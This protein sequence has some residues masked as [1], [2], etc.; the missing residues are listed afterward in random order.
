MT[1]QIERAEF[2]EALRL[3]GHM[4]KRSAIPILETVKVAAADGAIRL[5]A[6][7]MAR[8]ITTTCT[9][10][11]SQPFTTCLSA[12]VLADAIAGAPESVIQLTP[13][14]T[15]VDIKSGRM[16]AR[17]LGWPPEDFPDIRA[18]EEFSEV[19]VDTA[20]LAR[21]SAFASTAE[22]QWSLMGVALD[23]DHIVATDGYCIAT[24]PAECGDA[25][26]IIPTDGVV[27]LSKMGT[28]R[29]WVSANMWRAEAEG[30][31]ACGRL[32]DGT[33]PDWRSTPVARV[34]HLCS[35]DLAGMRQAV[36]SASIG[37]AL[38]RALA[39]I[40]GDSVEISGAGHLMTFASGALRVGISTERNAEQLLPGL[41]QAA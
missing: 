36:Q 40:A 31:Y 20:D 38:R 10:S 24:I 23:R 35:L 2:A 9:A 39:A 3:A 27:T 4:V 5:T 37:G 21:V 29:L 32:I 1:A 7:D 30:V 33:F 12:K 18:D 25:R 17:L 26:L 19:I 16:S 41:A 34:A 8:Q 6:C 11:V 15:D 28:P 13:S 14:K 22:V